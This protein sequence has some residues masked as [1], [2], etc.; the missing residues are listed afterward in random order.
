M[1]AE[2]KG[3]KK[4]HLFDTFE[5]M[6]E[7]DSSIDLHKKGDFQDTSIDSVKNYLSNYKDIY[8]YKG[9]FPASLAGTNCHT[10]T[11]S[12][13]NLDVDIYES[14]KSCLEFFYSR[15]NTGGIILSHDY[16][17]I[18]CPGVK[19]AIDEFFGKTRIYYRIM[20]LTMFNCENMIVSSYN[21]GNSQLT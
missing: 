11:F 19:K 4:L 12:F 17:S 21:N 10:L 16:R 5:G 2:V 6:P 13:V 14:T 20:G 1:I 3:N 9:Y 8:F 7:V 18:S 15:L